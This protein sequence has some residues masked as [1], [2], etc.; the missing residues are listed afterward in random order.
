[1]HLDFCLLELCTRPNTNITDKRGERSQLSI[2][3]VRRNICREQFQPS[4]II[5]VTLFESVLKFTPRAASWHFFPD[6]YVR[7]TNETIHIQRK[8]EVSW[9]IP[10][11]ATRGQSGA[12]RSRFC[13]SHRFLMAK[14]GWTHLETIHI[15]QCSLATLG[16]HT[17][18][19]NRRRSLSQC[20][21]TA[22]LRI[23]HFSL[24]GITWKNSIWHRRHGYRHAWHKSAQPLIISVA[25]LP[26]R[27]AETRSG[28]SDSQAA[29]LFGPLPSHK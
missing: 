6:L 26:V 24:P 8:R 27:G 20:P 28:P 2:L 13:S 29:S 25:A 22:G 17:M 23:L 11:P 7:W 12:F 18:Q 15:P 21:G 9:F 3:C 5:K 10:R 4:W 14:P 1:M 16:K 19:Q